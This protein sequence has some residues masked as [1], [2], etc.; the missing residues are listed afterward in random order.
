MVS[1]RIAAIVSVLALSLAIGDVRAADSPQQVT[2]RIAGC[3]DCARSTPVLSIWDESQFTKI[4]PVVSDQSPNGFAVSLAPGYYDLQLATRSCQDE[5]FLGV[6]AGFDRPFDVAMNCG[7]SFVRMVDY[8]HGLAG[9]LPASVQAITMH[10]VDGTGNPISGTVFDGAYYFDEANCGDCVLDL[11]LADGKQS[12]IGSTTPDRTNFSLVVDDLSQAA[13][14]AGTSVHGSPFNAPEQLVEGPSGTIWALDRLGNRV[15]QV[16]PGQT[17]REYELP[18]PFADAADIIGT[19]QFVWVSERRPEKIV[20]FAL[21]GSN[22]EFS[23]SL[24]AS[25]L[26]PNVLN[27]RMAL[28]SDGRVWYINGSTLGA[29][30]NQGKTTIYS[31]GKPVFWLRDLA[32]GADGRIWVVGISSTWPNSAN[33]I[34]A[35]DARGRWQRFPLVHDNAVIF[36]G[37]HGFWVAGDYRYLSYVDLHGHETPVVLPIADMRPRLLAVDATDEVWFTDRYGNMI[38]RAT[39]HGRITMTYTDG[40]AGISDMQ[41]DQGGNMWIAEPTAHAVEEYKKAFEWSPGLSPTRLLID[42]SDRLWYLDGAADVIG[43]IAKNGNDTCCTFPLAQI[44]NCRFQKM[45][46]EISSEP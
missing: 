6:L 34:A 14:T 29:I 33:F 4:H 12:R 24:P 26:S 21:D 7:K 18:T 36:S 43:V 40:L 20:R 41:A 22:V 1:P 46:V 31:D 10:S 15:A 32:L 23:I 13:V 30:D 27:F 17:Y 16:G 2:V 3:D 39:P 11:T 9:S 8:V 42:S 28:G 19:P 38:A 45:S 5:R 35:I 37:K 25:E 44:Q